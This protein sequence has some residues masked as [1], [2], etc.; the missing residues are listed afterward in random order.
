MISRA[1]GKCRA[2]RRVHMQHRLRLVAADRAQDWGFAGPPM[3]IQRII[4]VACSVIA[5]AALVLW[6]QRHFPVTWQNDGTM[7]WQTAVTPES[8]PSAP[9]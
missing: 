6:H 5:G 4:I 8:A 1:R 3:S 7:R 9:P 2:V